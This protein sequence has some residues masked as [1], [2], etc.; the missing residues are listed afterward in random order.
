MNAAWS[1]LTSLVAW[2]LDKTTKQW[3]NNFVAALI[4]LDLKSL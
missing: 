1:F 4:R 2:F 3:I